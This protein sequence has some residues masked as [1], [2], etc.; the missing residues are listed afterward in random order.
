[1]SVQ[2]AGAARGRGQAPGDVDEQP[3]AGLVHR[4]H[5]RQLP[6]GEPQGLHGVGHHLLMTDGDVD[7]IVLVAGLGDGE[8]RGDRPGSERSGS[9]RRPDTTRCPAGDR[10]APRSA[11]PAPRVPGNPR[12]TC[13]DGGSCRRGSTSTVRVPPP[14]TACTARCLAPTDR[15]RI[16]SPGRTVNTSGVTVPDTRASPR[17]KPASTV[18]TVRLPETGS[19]VNSTPA[20]S[21]RTMPLHDHGHAD[22][23]VLDAVVPPVD[24][25]PLG[26]Q[27]G[28]APADVP[29][30][31]LGSEDVEVGVLLSG[32]RGRRQVLRCA[33]DRT[34][35]A[36]PSPDPASAP[37]IASTTSSGR[38]ACPRSSGGSPR[39]PRGATPGPPDPR[40][41]AAR[42]PPRA[43][44]PP[45]APSG[46]PP[47]SY[48]N[49][50]APG[51]PR[52][53][54]AHPGA[55]PFLLRTRRVPRRPLADP[56]RTARSPR[57]LRAGHPHPRAVRP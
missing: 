44:A 49:R 32:E 52:S 38:G 24:H 54:T 26:E 1:M 33:L 56:T 42:C 8:Q 28:P 3:P 10:S 43:R 31:L 37:V 35:Y 27:R 19:A 53:G 16:S 7:V 21:G 51:C 5:G 30:H 12:V 6:H 45:P 15:A 46:G 17:P 29:Q 55:L 14:G 11:A 47:S 22:R 41:P 36:T 40:A 39:R 2:E 25:R 50:R 57:Q 23:S 34:A 20:A 13:S 9:R 4:H 48:R 18:A